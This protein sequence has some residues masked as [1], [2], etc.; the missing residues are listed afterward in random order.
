MGHAT[1]STTWEYCIRVSD[2]STQV[3]AEA[4]GR[5]VIDEAASGRKRDAEPWFGLTED[6]HG[7]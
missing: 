6:Q 1:V 5:W 3:A 2:A 7:S 4:H